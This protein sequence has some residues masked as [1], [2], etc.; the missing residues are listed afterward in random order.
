MAKSYF[1]LPTFTA[2]SMRSEIVLLPEPELLLLLGLQ[3]QLELRLEHVP[4]LEL[5]R[6]LAASQP[7]QLLLLVVGVRVGWQ[8]CFR[9]RLSLVCVSV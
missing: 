1:I 3:H 4:E 2:P 7:E 6:V 5:G 8:D 9:M